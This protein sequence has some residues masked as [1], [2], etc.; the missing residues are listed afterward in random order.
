MYIFFSF[1]S[2]KILCQRFTAASTS[3]YV[4]E[5]MSDDSKSLLKHYCASMK[6]IVIVRGDFK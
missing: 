4:R 6:K 1:F 2:K 3:A 5:L